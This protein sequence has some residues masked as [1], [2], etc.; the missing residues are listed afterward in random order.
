M[1]LQNQKLHKKISKGN[2][3]KELKTQAD[4]WRAILDGETLVNHNGFEVILV[5]GEARGENGYFYNFTIPRNWHIKEETYYRWKKE[6]NGE[7]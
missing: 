2:I 6:D 4:C 7:V 1:L 5:S 3:M